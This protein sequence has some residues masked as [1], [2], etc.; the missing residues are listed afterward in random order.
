MTLVLV[1]EAVLFQ[2]CT[3]RASQV[4]GTVEGVPLIPARTSLRDPYIFAF[5]LADSINTIF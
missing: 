3:H 5:Y 4:R 1:E 2:S